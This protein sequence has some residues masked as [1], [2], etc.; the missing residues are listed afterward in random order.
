MFVLGFWF[1]VILFYGFIFS[2]SE[3]HLGASESLRAD[4]RLAAWGASLGTCGGGGGLAG[5]DLLCSWA[6]RA[7][8][9]RGVEVGRGPLQ[10]GCQRW[11]ADS[12]PGQHALM[13]FHPMSDLLYLHPVRNTIS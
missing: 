9:F 5:S 11:G 1:V 10:L 4:E 2:I 8:G 3:E 6:R 13:L 7:Q 12:S